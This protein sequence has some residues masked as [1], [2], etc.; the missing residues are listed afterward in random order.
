ML[1][2][3]LF[4]IA[5]IYIY[6]ASKMTQRQNTRDTQETDNTPL[7]PEEKNCVKLIVVYFYNAPQAEFQT[8]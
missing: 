7:Q 3:T 8:A 2:A 5:K 1:N 6:V 4:T